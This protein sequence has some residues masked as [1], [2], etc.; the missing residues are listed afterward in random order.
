MLLFVVAAVLLLLHDHGGC[1][2]T[3]THNK[4]L[5]TRTIHA[6]DKQTIAW[7]TFLALSQLLL[8]YLCYH[9]AAG[10][11]WGRAQKLSC[12]YSGSSL[13]SFAS[14]FDHTRRL[15]P[16][17]FRALRSSVVR[18]VENFEINCLQRNTLKRRRQRRV[19]ERSVAR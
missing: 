18:R 11:G 9:T 4:T 14:I 16:V 8:H 13:R 7:V 2:H 15:P 6:A 1:S 19:G 17:F 3:H 10:R 5:N 12:N